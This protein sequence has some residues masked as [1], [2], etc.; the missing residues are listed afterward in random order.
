M[1]VVLAVVLLTVGTL[2][3]PLSV[4]TAVDDDTGFT[5]TVGTIVDDVKF[6]GDM[7]RCTG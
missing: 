3:S 6:F 2:I 7:M 5:G 1:V 4:F